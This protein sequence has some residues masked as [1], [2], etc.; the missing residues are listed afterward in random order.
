[1]SCSPRQ[2]F[3]SINLWTNWAD[4]LRRSKYQ[5]KMVAGTIWVAVATFIFVII[6]F[7]T[8]SDGGNRKKADDYTHT[9]K[10]IKISTLPIA[11]S[12]YIVL[13]EE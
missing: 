1:M 8:C 5:N 3:S 10:D 6:L 13:E 2:I 7:I 9:H 11:S 4:I 12:A